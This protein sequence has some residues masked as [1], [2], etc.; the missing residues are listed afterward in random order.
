MHRAWSPK[1]Q[2]S[3]PEQLSYPEIDK[4]KVRNKKKTAINYLCFMVY[5]LYHS[6]RKMGSERDKEDEKY[7]ISK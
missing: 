7:L 1:A 3:Y 6:K 2:T 4:K 5:F